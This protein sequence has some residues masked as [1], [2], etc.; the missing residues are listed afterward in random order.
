MT[1]TSFATRFVDD[2]TIP[3]ESVAE[4]VKRKIMTYDTNLM[5]VKV[6]FETGG[7]GTPH[8]HRHTQMSYVES[9]AFDITIADETKT[10]RTG[11]AYY[12]PPNIR[13]GAVCVEAGVLVDVFTP[14]REDFV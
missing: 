13:H 4:G 14:M 8:E 10:L 3:W 6:A 1:E 2:Q 12:I 11:D 7:I 5:M 9:G